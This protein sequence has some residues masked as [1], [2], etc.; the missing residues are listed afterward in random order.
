QG[1]QPQPCQPQRF[2]RQAAAG[3]TGLAASMA[4]R[5]GAGATPSG[6]ARLAAMPRAN[7]A[8]ATRMNPNFC[9]SPSLGFPSDEPIPPTTAILWGF[10]AFQAYRNGPYD[11]NCRSPASALLTCTIGG[12]GI[13]S[14]RTSGEC[15]SAPARPARSARRLERWRP[16]LPDLARQPPGKSPRRQG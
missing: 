5:N 15:S 2:S 14:D 8:T 9:I 6:S 16:R 4:A 10:A 7:T 3:S 13:L 11:G 1:Y 12:D